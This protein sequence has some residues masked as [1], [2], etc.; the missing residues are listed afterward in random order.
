MASVSKEIQRK[1]IE[2]YRSELKRRYQLKNV[3]RFSDF[4]PIPDEQIAALREYFLQRIYPPIKEREALDHAIDRLGIVLTSPRHLRPLMSIALKTIWRLGIKL[5]SAISAGTATVDAYR[6]TRKLE[7]LLFESAA[8]LKIAAGDVVGRETMIRLITEVPAKDVERLIHDI[9]K[10]F[11]ALSN[12]EMLR[13][14][15]ELMNQFI[16]AMK[17]HPALFTDE[18]A[19]GVALGKEVVEG[20]LALFVHIEPSHFPGIIKGIEAIEF[21]WYQTACQD[22]EAL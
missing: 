12:T 11:H 2:F 4:D 10:L 15:V 20:G 8:R 5:P 7:G 22:A 19:E 14:A 1:I 9:L 3:R 6:E 13:V 21:D 16:A 18:D 17:H